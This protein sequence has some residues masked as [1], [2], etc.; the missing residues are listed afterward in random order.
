MVDLSKKIHKMG[1]APP[2]RCIAC[3]KSFDGRIMSFEYRGEFWLTG[4]FCSE[5]CFSKTG[6]PFS[7]KPVELTGSRWKDFWAKRSGR[8][9]YTTLWGKPY[10][11]YEY[12]IDDGVVFDVKIFSSEE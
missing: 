1:V 2:F 5:E 4:N 3:G 8:T 6:I 9:A 10:D 11:I 12:K 7:K